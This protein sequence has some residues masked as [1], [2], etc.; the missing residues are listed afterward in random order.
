M[1]PIDDR[2]DNERI[3]WATWDQIEGTRV[4]IL[5]YGSGLQIWDTSNLN[6]VRE[7]LNLKT[8]SL[9]VAGHIQ[10]ALA[11]PAPADGPDDFVNA[12]PLLGIM[13]V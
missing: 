2:T 3:V 7:I 4:L 13:S 11:L 8:E 6:A 10:C 12:R 9:H 5:A 1:S